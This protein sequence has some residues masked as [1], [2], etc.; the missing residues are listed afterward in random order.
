MIQTRALRYDYAQG[1]TLA[2]DDLAV[3]QGASVILRGNSGAGKSTWLALVAG[4]LSPTQGEIIV[5]GQALSTF[6]ASA[7]D[8]W[9]AKNVGFLPQKLHLSPALSVADNLALAYFAAGLPRDDA[10]IDQAL[11]ATFPRTIS[12]AGC[13][14]PRS[15][16]RT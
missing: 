7:R 8:A 12:L 10:A 13:T 16:A 1:S 2:F 3:P 15:A 6:N 11:L 14:A 5:A 4:L 9:R